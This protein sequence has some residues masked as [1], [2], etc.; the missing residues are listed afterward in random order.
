MAFYIV[1][2]SGMPVG[3][4]R[5]SARSAGNVAASAAGTKFAV[6]SFSCRYNRHVPIN[7]PITSGTR[8]GPYE[9][10]AAL[11]AGGMGEVY[12]ARD[13]RLDR[14][15]AIK[16]LPAQFASDPQL[17][18]RFDREARAISSLNHP[19]ICALYDVGEAPSP[20]PSAL[21]HDA[22]QFLVL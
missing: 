22:I 20:E 13:T 1:D 10:V 9:V 14:I 6:R 19:H 16:V 11:G 15:V 7:M 2:A 18:E 3:L 4:A 17:R 12:R 21:S 5:K 8:L